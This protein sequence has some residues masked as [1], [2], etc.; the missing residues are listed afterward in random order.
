[1]LFRRGRGDAQGG[2][3]FQKTL[4]NKEMAK[5]FGKSGAQL[6]S[7]RLARQMEIIV[8]WEYAQRD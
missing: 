7:L 4:L 1:M 8:L 2:F 3:D 5:M 6:Q